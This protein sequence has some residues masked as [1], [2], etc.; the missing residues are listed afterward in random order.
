MKELSWEEIYKD[1]RNKVYY[2]VYLLMGEEPF[3]ID[4]ISNIIE[5][6]VLSEEEKEFNQTILY[7]RE[8]DVAT[9]IST[10]K[11]FPMMANHQVV[12]IKEAQNIKNIENLESYIKNP[13]NSTILVICYKYKSLDKRKSLYKS[14]GK[15]G[16]ILES[17]KVYDN[18]MPSWIASYAKRSGYTIGD[19]A[20]QMLADH[21]GN[22]LGKVVNEMKKVFISLPKGEEVTTSLIEKNIG[23]SKDFNIFELQNAIGEKDSLKAFQI[24]KYFADNPKSNPIVVTLAVLHGYFTK[25]LVYHSLK[26]KSQRNVAAELG[27]PPFFVSALQKAASK[28]PVPK[29]LTILSDFRTYDLRSKGVNNGSTSHGELLKELVYKI[30]N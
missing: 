19:K 25:M 17:K 15:T 29:L 26:D 8:T 11:R 13:L 1:L 20:R 23:I 16:V 5:E 4:V 9:I 21:L 2:P 14:L 10:A 3:Y 12:I 27:I 28:Y 30:L 24:V 22:D 18:E 7:G 6:K